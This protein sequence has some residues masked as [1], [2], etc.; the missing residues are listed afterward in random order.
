M[1]VTGNA[2]DICLCGVDSCLIDCREEYRYNI[3]A[4][5]CL[6]HNQLVLTQQYDLYV[7]Q[8]ID[9]GSNY[10]ALT[11]AMQL[12][13]RFCAD[14]DKQG[15]QRLHEVKDSLRRQLCDWLWETSVWIVWSPIRLLAALLQIMMMIIMRP[16]EPVSIRL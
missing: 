6:L 9:N 16:Y 5:E 15:Q 8:S 1:Q 3:D 4:V 13:Q 10:M 7:A 2:S 14:T 12:I 11:F